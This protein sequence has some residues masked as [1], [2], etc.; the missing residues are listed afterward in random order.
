MGEIDDLPFDELDFRYDQALGKQCKFCG[1]DGFWW[2]QTEKGWRL[3]DRQGLHLC[4]RP[5]DANDKET[6]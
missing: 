5:A 3:A 6:T 2:V 4:R 1:E